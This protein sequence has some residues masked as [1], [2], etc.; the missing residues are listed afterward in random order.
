MPTFGPDLSGCPW[1]ARLATG[2]TLLCSEQDRVVCTH[3]STAGVLAG[4]VEIDG[5]KK[6]FVFNKDAKYDLDTSVEKLKIAVSTSI[7]ILNCRS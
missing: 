1:L 7:S 3:P 5:P 2:H 6:W 4:G